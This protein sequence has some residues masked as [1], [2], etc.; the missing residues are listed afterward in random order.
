MTEISEAART[1][2][3]EITSSPG[4]RGLSLVE[5]LARFIQ[6]VSDA[7]KD[8]NETGVLDR[9]ILPEPVDP[10]VEAIGTALG[11]MRGIYGKEDLA[12]L[13]REA[14]AKRGLKIVGEA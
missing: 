13:V 2:A 4:G 7:A 12:P 5:N 10:L 8:A 3:Y 14:L 11:Q 6:E 9:F 1:R